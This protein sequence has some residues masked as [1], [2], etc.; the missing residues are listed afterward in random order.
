M[1]EIPRTSEDMDTEEGN[2]PM[3]KESEN[4]KTKSNL[5]KQMKSGKGCF[6]RKHKC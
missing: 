6:R 5:K 4:E 2:D 1:E 3:M